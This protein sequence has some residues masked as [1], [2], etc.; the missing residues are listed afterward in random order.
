MAIAETTNQPAGTGGCRQ[1]SLRPQCHVG[2]NL[3]L[4]QLC[5]RTGDVLSA[6]RGFRKPRAVK[7]VDTDFVRRAIDTDQA[8]SGVRRVGSRKAE[9]TSEEQGGRRLPGESSKLSRTIG[10]RFTGAIVGLGFGIAVSTLLLF[11]LG[12]FFYLLPFVGFAP[13]LLGPIVG[14]VLARLGAVPHIRPLP[15]VVLALVIASSPYLAGVVEMRLRELPLAVPP[16]A[17]VI[18]WTKHPWGES[19]VILE[20]AEEVPAFFDQLVASANEMGWHCRSC[21]YQSSTGTGHAS[22]GTRDSRA[23]Q[24]P[25]FA[26]VEVWS[27]EKELYRTAPSERNVARIFHDL[28]TGGPAIA[29][30][31]WSIL[32]LAAVVSHLARMLFL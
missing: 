10:I 25:G 21:F 8:N 13:I 31:F 2:E 19:V 23:G 14:L 5:T 9:K 20:S 1:C 26:G 3:L 28:Q 18:Q 6:K 16:D 29:V 27:G 7:W 30:F 24:S 17:E 15:T 22:F 12:G 4:G 11:R 32:L